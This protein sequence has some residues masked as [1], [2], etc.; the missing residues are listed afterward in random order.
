MQPFMIVGSWRKQLI[1]LL[2]GHHRLKLSTNQNN[3]RDFTYKHFFLLFI[4]LVFLG[5]NKA[6]KKTII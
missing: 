4:F 6:H 2:Y 1:F 5:Y 3:D